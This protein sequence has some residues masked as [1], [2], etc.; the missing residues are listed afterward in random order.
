MS[1]TMNDAEAAR[2][3]SRALI[4]GALGSLVGKTIFWFFGLAPLSDGMGEAVFILCFIFPLLYAI[5]AVLGA[6]AGR[7]AF[8]KVSKWWSPFVAGLVLGFVAAAVMSGLFFL[9]DYLS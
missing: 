1:E 2:K 8:G 3:L 6:F 5:C 4:L 7:M 9:M